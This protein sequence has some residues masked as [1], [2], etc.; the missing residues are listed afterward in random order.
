M[1]EQSGCAGSIRALHPPFPD[2]MEDLSAHIDMVHQRTVQWLEVQNLDILNKL[3]DLRRNAPSSVFANWEPDTLQESHRSTLLLHDPVHAMAAPGDDDKASKRRPAF[4][5]EVDITEVSVSNDRSGNDSWNQPISEK[6]ARSSSSNN[7][8]GDSGSRPLC[9][10]GV[11]D[12]PVDQR[13]LNE[14]FSR[15]LDA[16]HKAETQTAPE[17]RLRRGTNS[18]CSTIAADSLLSIEGLRWAVR[19]ARF[20]LFCCVVIVVAAVNTGIEVQRLSQGRGR[21]SILEH[22]DTG[23]VVWYTVELL[24]RLWADGPR[25]SQSNSPWNA[26]DA[27]FLLLSYVNVS[28]D[29]SE[30]PRGFSVVRSLRFLRILRVLKVLKL[31]QNQTMNTYFL[32]F[33]KMAFSLL[34]SLP[35]L[36]SAA[37]V[38]AVFTYITAVLLTQSIT[39]HRTEMGFELESGSL[40]EHFGSLDRSFY[41][42]VKAIFGG[43]SWGELLPPLNAVG[44]VPVSVFWLYLMLSMLCF[45]NVINGVFVDSA[46]QS[47]AHYKDLMVAEAQ[48]KKVVLLQHLREV[49]KEMDADGSGY[50]TVAEFD[51]C[52]STPGGRAFFE[53]MGLSTVEALELFRLMD[54][55]FSSSVDIDEFCEGCM[56]VM[57]EAKNFDIQ[58]ILMENRQVLDKWNNFIDNF[59]S[60][61]KAIMG[62]QATV[63]LH[64]S[65]AVGSKKPSPQAQLQRGSS[66]GSI[67]SSRYELYAVEER[68]EKDG[69]E[70]WR[71]LGGTEQANQSLA[72]TPVAANGVT[73]VVNGLDNPRD[74]PCA[75][76]S[77]ACA[78]KPYERQRC[79]L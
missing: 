16:V 1:P 27:F 78:A 65:V 55:D 3:A 59:D 33:S 32:V 37:T 60:T 20:D 24:L 23:L 8:A 58:C 11:T 13:K 7:R 68:D 49:F 42:L 41:S 21:G 19:S 66:L 74:R 47:T 63:S 17:L 73:T 34:Q 67:G 50:I 12:R 44:T 29:L 53:V 36:I 9:S 46:L 40:V 39:D 25:W 61:M 4:L 57:G 30:V 18:M 22:I 2:A 62:M 71:S 54:A 28:V 79:N 38:I 52:L 5:D 10:R 51:A 45:L 70:S 15:L 72:A 69:F 76:E 6:S 48:K 31:G 43:Q 75:E 77:S 35:S 26:F 14:G 56:K 64:P